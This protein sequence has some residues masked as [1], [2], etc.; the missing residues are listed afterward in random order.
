MTIDPAAVET[1]RKRVAAIITSNA[2]SLANFRGPLIQEIISHGW[3]VFA[4]APDFDEKT[5]E[6]MRRIGAEPIDI[7]LERTTMRPLRDLADAVRLMLL[8]RRLRPQI[9]LSYF[10]KPVIYGSLA[11]WLARTGPRY[12]LVPGMGYVFA[13]HEGGFRRRLLQ[14]FVARL[15]GLAFKTC[16]R[17][18]FQN[19]DDVAQFSKAGLLD[20]EKAVLLT[21]T[22]VDMARFSPA[23]PVVAPIRFLLLARLLRAKGI[24]DFVEAGRILRRRHPDIEIVLAGGF[25]PNPDGLTPE[26]VQAWVDEGAVRW[27]GHIDDVVPAIAMSSVY[28]LPSYYREGVP[29]SS[30][31]A[32]AMARP[33][34]TTDWIGCRETVEDGVN[35]FLV[36]VRNP[37]AL[38]E[39]ME[40]FVEDPSLIE[41]MGRESRRIAE[42]RFDVRKINARMIGVLGIRVE[43]K[44]MSA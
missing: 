19:S 14:D 31:E 9:V 33:V 16:S 22:G 4:L 5:R 1:D 26:E 43:G 38:A 34:V 36:P 41:R 15:Y 17:V 39:A 27:L 2:Y 35:G 29:R 40:R 3:R 44:E 6:R 25:D 8:L 30:Q 32:M 21:G 37:T 20:R 28:V 24:V 7:S 10:I 18:F 12:A 13:A 11:A 42:E 23:P